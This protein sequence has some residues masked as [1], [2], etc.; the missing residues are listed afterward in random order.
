MLKFADFSADFLFLRGF[1]V[2]LWLS[3]VHL[4]ADE[5]QI[6]PSAS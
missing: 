4:Y 5:N 3:T 2:A 6:T 1:L